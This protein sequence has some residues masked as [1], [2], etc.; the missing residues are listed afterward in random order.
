MTAEPHTCP[1]CA[2]LRFEYHNEVLDD[3]RHDHRDHAGMVATLE[4]HEMP[5][6]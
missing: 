5:H 2:V 1:Y 4:I 6:G 3:I